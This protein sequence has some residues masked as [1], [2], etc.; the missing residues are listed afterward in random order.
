F[1]R[2]MW[3]WRHLHFLKCSGRMNDPEGPASTGQGELAF[4]C[5]ACPHPEINLPP[6]WEKAP[7][8]MFWL[9]TLFIGIDANFQLKRKDVSSDCADPRLRR[10]WSYF[11][12]EG[13]YQ[14][15]LKTCKE[16]VQ[17]RFL[18]HL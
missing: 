13:K 5:P 8:Q 17:V 4:K 10:G 9:Y 18:L 16:P 7:L 14:D 11:V 1:M 12:K 6:D 15:Y 3:E 2:M